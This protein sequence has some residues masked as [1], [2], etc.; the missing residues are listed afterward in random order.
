MLKV[1]KTYERKQS[2]VS[3]GYIDHQGVWL[4]VNQTRSLRDRCTHPASAFI[5]LEILEYS[6]LATSCTASVLQTFNI[7]LLTSDDLHVAFYN[8]SFAWCCCFC[9]SLSDV[10]V[11]KGGYVTFHQYFGYVIRPFNIA[12]RTQC[13]IKWSFTHTIQISWS[14]P[15]STF[16]FKIWRYTSMSLDSDDELTQNYKFAEYIVFCVSDHVFQGKSDAV[17]RTHSFQE[18]C[19]SY[20]C[21]PGFYSSPQI[22]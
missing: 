1:T 9:W 8:V 10:I 12:F 2:P 17:R 7:M 6:V 11:V 16:N 13:A 18:I 3:A 5:M 20:T 19:V 21:Q 4:R 22:H 14:Q 15:I